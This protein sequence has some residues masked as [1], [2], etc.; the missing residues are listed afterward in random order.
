MRSTREKCP[1]PR[2]RAV[3][4]DEDFGKALPLGIYS[5]G[6]VQRISLWEHAGF[7]L[8]SSRVLRIL[9]AHFFLAPRSVFT[10]IVKT[11]YSLHGNGLSVEVF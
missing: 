1:R 5:Y 3:G 11:V 6:Q 10:S 2:G 9:D 7:T 4:V 8:F